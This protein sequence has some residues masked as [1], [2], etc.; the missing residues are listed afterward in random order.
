MTG[1]ENFIRKLDQG[2][3]RKLESFYTD[4]G[5]VLAKSLI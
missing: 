5:G 3:V 1:V 2:P 4:L